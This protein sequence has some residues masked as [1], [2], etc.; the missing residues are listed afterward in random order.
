MAN[1]PE[2]AAEFENEVEGEALSDLAE[3]EQEQA[4]MMDGLSEVAANASNILGEEVTP[5]DIASAI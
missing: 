3:A 4:A 5:E 1:D 2:A